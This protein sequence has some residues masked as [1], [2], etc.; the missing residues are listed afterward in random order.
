MELAAVFGGQLID[1]LGYREGFG[2]IAG[3]I[4]SADEVPNHQ[5]EDLVG[6]DEAAVAIDGANAVAIAIRSEARVILSG[7][8][9]LAQRFDVRLDRSGCTPPKRASRV[10]EFHRISRHSG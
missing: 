6:V 8:N 7:K 10:R 5:H 1:Q 9:R 4:S 2:D 3:K